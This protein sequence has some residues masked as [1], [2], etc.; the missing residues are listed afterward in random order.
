M[1]GH[2]DLAAGRWRTLEFVE[3][4]AN[5]GSEVGRALSSRRSGN[6]ERSQRAF[7]RALELFD[8]TS[9]D[10]RWR[11]SRLREIRRAR[12]EFCRLHLEEQ[13]E[14]STAGFEKYF[15]AFA[16]SARRPDRGAGRGGQDPG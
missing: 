13:E 15:L 11:G 7:E 9:A 4:M 5:V 10:P 8:L 1:T 12:E 3:Q 14:A 16:F 2:R 6:W